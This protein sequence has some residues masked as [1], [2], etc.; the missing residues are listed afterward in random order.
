M[1]IDNFAVLTHTHSECKDVLVPYISSH[2]EF[3]T[4]QKHYYLSN[5]IVNESTILYDPSTKFS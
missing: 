2:E 1:G 3:F 5:E 4:G